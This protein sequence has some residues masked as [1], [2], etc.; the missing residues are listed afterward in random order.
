MKIIKST[1]HPLSHY[2]PVWLCGCGCVFFKTQL[3]PFDYKEKQFI[4]YWVPPVFCV[5]NAAFTKQ[6]LHAFFA[7]FT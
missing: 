3:Q 6:E 7:L 2:E 4:I 1:T 5:G